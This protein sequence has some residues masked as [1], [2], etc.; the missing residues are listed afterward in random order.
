MAIVSQFSWSHLFLFLLKFIK[1]Y[2][3]YLCAYLYEN[4]LS[5]IIMSFKYLPLESWDYLIK[6]FVKLTF[7][8]AFRLAPTHLWLGRKSCLV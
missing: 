1:R 7:K 8:L 3:I 4:L 6:A 2:F 5:F